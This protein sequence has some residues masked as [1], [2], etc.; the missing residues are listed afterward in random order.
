VQFDIGPASQELDGLGEREMVDLLNKR[1]DI[2]AHPTTET[3]V[4]ISRG[5]DLKRRRFLV[6]ERAQPLEA[7]PAGALELQVLPH[8]LVDLRPLTDQRDV[9]GPDASP[10]GHR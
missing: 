3:M 5:S 8:D 10:P 1:N 4:E 7:A 2:A 9:R 6:V